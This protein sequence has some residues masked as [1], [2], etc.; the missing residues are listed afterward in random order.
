MIM[1]MN[2]LKK[3]ISSLAF[4]IIRKVDF[5]LYEKKFDDNDKNDNII[6]S[7]SKTVINYETHETGIDLY[8][9]HHS[10]YYY[11]PLGCESAHRILSDQTDDKVNINTIIEEMLGELFIKSGDGLDKCHRAIR[12]FMEANSIDIPNRIS[13]DDTL[14]EKRIETIYDALSK[15]DFNI[16]IKVVASNNLNIL[17]GLKG[18][19][20][21]WDKTPNNFFYIE[22]KYYDGKYKASRLVCDNFYSLDDFKKF[23]KKVERD[24]YP[25]LLEEIYKYK[26][27]SDSTDLY[28]GRELP[29]MG[30]V[31]KHISKKMY[32]VKEVDQN[33][34]IVHTVSLD[35]DCSNQDFDLTLF[36]ALAD[37]NDKAEY[38][39][40]IQKYKFNRVINVTK[41]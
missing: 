38:P 7:L 33:N 8:L 36:M 40:T 24:A 12:E 11:T 27:N 14:T 41:L 31:Y 1:K 13:L 28:N 17:F 22:L 6:L 16:E 35:S 39:H 9:I 15:Y 10:P 32:F 5:I 3:Q 30:E 20:G 37:K 21:I 23:I 4:N 34:G 25:S 2:E 18:N 26:K 29:R 19:S